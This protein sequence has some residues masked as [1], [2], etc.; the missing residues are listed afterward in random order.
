MER[1]LRWYICFL[2]AVFQDLF[3]TSSLNTWYWRK[4]WLWCFVSNDSRALGLG[5]YYSHNNWTNVLFITTKI[6]VSNKSRV[7]RKYESPY[8][9]RM[10]WI[11]ASSNRPSIHH[12]RVVQ[13]E[14]AHLK[15]RGCDCVMRLWWGRRGYP[16]NHE[17][18]QGSYI[19]YKIKND[20]GHNYD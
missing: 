7:V 11:A 16:A 14:N 2:S 20:S 15:C 8:R 3:L 1:F 17:D 9:T 18:M 12:A 5:A 6:W 19:S 13:C 4:I 10:W